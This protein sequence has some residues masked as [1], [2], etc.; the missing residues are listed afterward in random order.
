MTKQDRKLA[1]VGQ[2]LEQMV[3]RQQQLMRSL[4][5]LKK[6]EKQADWMFFSIQHIHVYLMLLIIFTV[7]IR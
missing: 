4:S 3:Q 6:K 1:E 5:K 7:R 2:K